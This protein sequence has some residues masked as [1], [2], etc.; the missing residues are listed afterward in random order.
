MNKGWIERPKGTTKMPA[1][2]MPDAMVEVLLEGDVAPY[3]FEAGEV[4]WRDGVGCVHSYRVLAPVGD[5]AG[6]AW[7]SGARFN[8]EKPDLSLIPAGILARYARFSADLVRMAGTA[9]DW[10]TVLTCL[11]GFQMRQSDDAESLM[12]ALA[13]MDNDGKLWADCARVF[14]YG[15]EKYSPWNWARGQAWSIPIGSALRHVVWG[16]LQGELIDPESGL[17]HRGHIACNI[18]MLLWFA[19]EYAQGDDRFVRPD[20]FVATK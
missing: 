10:A 16:P 5:V 1:G 17:P 15:K 6:T 4:N 20:R 13:E 7:G 2:L 14:S 3:R 11:G 19:E 8:G 18:V 9:I 12:F